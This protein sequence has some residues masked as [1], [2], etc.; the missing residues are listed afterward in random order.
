MIAI[1]PYSLRSRFV[2]A[3]MAGVT[4]LP[5]RELVWRMN[6]GLVVSEMVTSRRELLDSK[7]T[8]ERRVH[9]PGAVPRAVQIAGAEPELMARAARC[10]VAHGAQII[11]INMGCPAKKVC[12]KLAGSALMRDERRVEEILNAVIAAVDVPVTLKMRTGWS[13]EMR[14]GISI[15]RI[16]EDVGI[17]ALAVHGRTRAC[18]FEGAAEY[19]TI[20]RIKQAVDIPVIANGDIDSPEKAR[21]VLDYTGADAVMV[22]RAAQGR[23]WL[24]KSIGHYLETGE[25]LPEPGGEEV[26]DTIEE[27]L[28]RLYD[29]YGVERGIRIARKHVGWYLKS[30]PGGDEF[31]RAFNQLESSAEQGRFVRQ[32]IGER[33][34][35]EG[36]LPLAA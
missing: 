9:V 18:R 29:F 12:N 26:A 27:H 13:S 25:K 7:M 36:T 16:A 8:R 15:A 10:N 22:G 20:A 11:D 21:M 6:A 17:G 35:R 5:F 23:P 1:G 4:D 19:D 32:Q 3:P 34:R 31:R 2:L 24:A 33:L 28:R 14:N 30:V